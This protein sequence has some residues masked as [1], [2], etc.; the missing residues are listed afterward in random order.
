MC[1]HFNEG[2]V[3][4]NEWRSRK[5]VLR[6]GPKLA[7][8]LVLVLVLLVSL[9]APVLVLALAIALLLYP[10][11]SMADGSKLLLFMT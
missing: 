7:L 4:A 9:L 8:A 6:L 10:L 1:L 2:N 3:S 5:G 11:I